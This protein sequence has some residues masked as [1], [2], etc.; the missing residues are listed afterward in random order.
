MQYASGGSADFRKI[1]AELAV[2]HIVVGSVRRVGPTLRVSAQ[3]VDTRTGAQIWAESFDRGVSDIFAVETQLAEAIVTQLHAKLSPGEKAAI[4]LPPTSDLDAFQLYTEARELHATS[5]MALGEEKRLQAIELLEGA[6]KHDPTF[7]RAYCALVRI[8]SE[9]YLLGMDH[10]P[11]RLQVAE[12]AL[13]NAIRLQ[14]EAGETHLAAA[15]LRYCQL[16]YDDARRELVLAQRAL[17]NESF[18]FELGGYMDRRQGRWDESERNL[19]RA[20]DLDPRNFYFLQQLSFSYER[21]R[22]FDDMRAVMDRAVAIA[23]NDPGARINRA[24]ADLF[25]HADTKPERAAFDALLRENSRVSQDLAVELI[26][27]ALCERDFPAADRAIAEMD[28]KEGLEGAFAFP[29]EWYAGLISRAKGDANAARA[30]FSAARSEVVQ[31]LQEQG[32]FPQPL[33]VLAMIDA[34]LG[35]KEAAITAGRRACQ[36]LPVSQDAIT[37]ADIQTHLAI[38]YTWCGEKEQALDQIFLLSKIPSDVNYGIL[39]LD[40]VWDPLRS[41]PRFAKIVASL[42]PKAAK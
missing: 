40:P 23:P 3:L 33:S 22:R 28:E 8:H 39:R 24:Q 36:L 1:A 9:V 34:A 38:T 17:P 15:F 20:L 5:A 16:N 21:L 25:A 32:E 14:P 30:A 29:R 12:T 27:L 19:R 2:A 7:L 4:A 41:N 35:N 31:A 42:A 11:A 18:V 13:Q 26:H 10:T 6:T 37:G